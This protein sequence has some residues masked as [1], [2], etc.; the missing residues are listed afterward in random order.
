MEINFDRILAFLGTALGL[1][2]IYLTL[3][4]SKRTRPI[5]IFNSLN[6]L[7]VSKT[8]FEKL[9][10][11]YDNKIIKQIT[12]TK[13]LIC[14]TG[15]SLLENNHIPLHYRINIKAKDDKIIF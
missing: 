4:Y 14:N 1:V 6:L 12:I 11:S 2:G 15:N 5:I 9:N 8:N 10:V 13:I 3:K 7:N